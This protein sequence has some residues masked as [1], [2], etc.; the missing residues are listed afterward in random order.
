MNLLKVLTIASAS[1]KE[2]ILDLL[3]MLRLHMVT[4]GN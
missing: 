1:P 3:I 2:R 4:A